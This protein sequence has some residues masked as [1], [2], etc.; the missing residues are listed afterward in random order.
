MYAATKYMYHYDVDLFR[1]S[2]RTMPLFS[3]QVK[4]PKIGE[5]NRQTTIYS[6]KEEF[7]GK[8]LFPV[9]PLPGDR[10]LQ[11]FGVA[12]VKKD[13]VRMNARVVNEEGVNEP[14][15]HYIDAINEFATAVKDAICKQ[16]NKDPKLFKTVIAP[17][18]SGVMFMKAPAYFTD[19]GQLSDKRFDDAAQAVFD[20]QDGEVMARVAMILLTEPHSTSGANV[21]R[22]V[23]IQFQLEPEKFTVERKKMSAVVPLR[24]KKPEAAADEQ[25]AKRATKRKA[26]KASAKPVKAAKE[27]QPKKKVKAEPVP[28][29]VEVPEPESEEM[30]EEQSDE[31]DEEEEEADA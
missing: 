3:E 6:I 18:D 25:A 2:L 15:R 31:S 22:T 14:D 20:A 13:T 19:K 16:N 24:K 30:D 11:Y 7:S 5:N 23:Y 28:V 17:N 1:A 9:I 26:V 12:D 4:E 29:K 27:T 8:K 10:N 21:E